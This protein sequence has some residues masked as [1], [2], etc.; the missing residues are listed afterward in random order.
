VT[1]G[2]LYMLSHLISKQ[3]SLGC[4]YFGLNSKKSL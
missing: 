1:A 2:V 3:A 4:H